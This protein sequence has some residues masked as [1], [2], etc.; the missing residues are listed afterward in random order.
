MTRFRCAGLLFL[1]LVCLSASACSGGGR[2]SSSGSDTQS[3]PAQSIAEDSAKVLKRSVVAAL[4]ANHRLSRFVLSRN[5]L[6]AW[7]SQSTR[8]PALVA[9]RSSAAKRRRRG[10]RIRVV[11]DRFVIQTVRLDASYS[12]ATATILNPQQVRPYGRDGTPLGRS[13]Q[14][15]ERAQYELHRIGSSQRFVVWKAIPLR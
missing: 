5:R 6:P 12:A 14:L 9:L 13:V 2:N 11:S 3:T 4:R 10:I 8:G 15:I 1:L 7:A